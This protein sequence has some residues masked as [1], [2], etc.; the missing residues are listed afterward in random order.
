MAKGGKGGDGGAAAA[1]AEEQQRQQRIR[2]GT[3]NINNTFNSQFTDD[4]FNTR[5]QSALDYYTPQLNQQYEDAKKAL[6]YSLDRSG[7]LDSSMR[8]EKEA[9]L[10]RLYDT[11]R[12]SVADQALS[13]A[14]STRSN[15]ENARAD[16]ISTL[17]ATG[18][19]QG[20]ANSA[21]SRASILSQP[22]SYNPLGQLFL[23]FTSGLGQ[24][25][26]Q[27]KANALLSNT[28]APSTTLN[29]GPRK[30]SVV[31]TQ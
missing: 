18:D 16:L 5:Q 4:Y 19:A 27:E 3:E 31:T 30:G 11:N 20:A 13:M 12:R 2:E 28:L 9:E 17:N 23:S 25:A 26:A 1:R 6:T 21:I 7:T 15:V 14:N 24:Q 29:Y 10:M 8:A 22:D